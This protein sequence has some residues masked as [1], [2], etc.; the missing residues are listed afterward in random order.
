MW[1]LAANLRSI[2][3]FSK[4][5]NAGIQIEK[6]S[7]TV[8]RRTGEAKKWGPTGVDFKTFLRE[9]SVGIQVEK[10]Y[11]IPNLDLA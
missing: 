2:G 5:G 10:L 3:A 4:P 8:R 9:G 1:P 7:E 11:G 6:L